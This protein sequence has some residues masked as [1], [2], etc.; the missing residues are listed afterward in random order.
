MK[1]RWEGE[2][3]KLRQDLGISVVE[4]IVTIYAIT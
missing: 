3:V 1:I 2:N 4:L